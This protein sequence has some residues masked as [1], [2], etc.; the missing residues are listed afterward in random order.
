MMNKQTALLL[1]L[2]AFQRLSSSNHPPRRPT[3]LD[4][5]S[6][7]R[8]LSR[9]LHPQKMSE[10][11]CRRPRNRKSRHTRHPLRNRQSNDRKACALMIHREQRIGA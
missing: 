10:S 7:H 9:R 1:M 11:H 3:L 8:W 5:S 2:R 4:P 6:S